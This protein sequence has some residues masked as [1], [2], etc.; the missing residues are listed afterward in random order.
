MVS[1]HLRA[2]YDVILPHLLTHIEEAVALEDIARDYRSVFYEFVLVT[3]KAE[4]VARMMER[5]TWGEPGS[6]PL[7]QNDIPIIEGIFDK[8]QVTVSKRPNTIK[9]NSIKGNAD[10]TYKQLITSLVRNP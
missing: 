8:V 2:G 1:T 4:A 3:D 10:D 6:P 5:G 9:L 7:T